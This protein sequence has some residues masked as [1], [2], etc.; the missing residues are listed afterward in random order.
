M[1]L[2]EAETTND[3]E[4]DETDALFMDVGNDD[5]VDAPRR[6]QRRR[7]ATRWIALG[8]LVA[9]V[10][11]A[12]TAPLF[13]GDPDIGN[14]NILV[15]PLTHGTILGTD[16]LGRDVL[17]RLIF[18]ARSSLT[19]VGISIVLVVVLGLFLG[20]VAGYYRKSVETVIT[21]I[22]DIF[23]AFPGLVFLLVVHA[24]LGSSIEMLVVGFLFIGT[25]TFMRLARANT[26]AIAQREYVRAARGIGAKN[27]EIMFR[28]I[29]PNVW[30]AVSAYG[31]TLMATF[32]VIEGSLAYLGL[33]VPPPASSWGRMIAEG[34]IVMERQAHLIIIPSLT[35]M[36]TI[37]AINRLADLGR[38]PRELLDVPA[39]AAPEPTS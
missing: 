10:T 17:T 39:V 35:L 25:P 26:I 9:L 3:F 31:F 11:A 22:G 1:A 4:V 15:P 38:D 20:V 6:Q 23:L 19:V 7:R 12:I 32:F 18:G 2:S 27:R 13:L 34:R 8:W 16:G 30:P 21:G 28:D 5:E 29:L 37:M 33:S 24:V 36:I 14:E